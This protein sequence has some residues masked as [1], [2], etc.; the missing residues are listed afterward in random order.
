MDRAWPLVN[1]QVGCSSSHKGLEALGP[2]CGGLAQHLG[3]HPCCCGFSHHVPSR[4]SGS[5]DG[6]DGEDILRM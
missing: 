5:Q 1:K 6:D 3:L 2:S 4:E